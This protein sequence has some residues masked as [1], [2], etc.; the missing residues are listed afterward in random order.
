MPDVL[1]E[2]TFALVPAYRILSL[3]DADA[4]ADAGYDPGNALGQAYTAV[5]AST[6]TELHLVCA[7]AQVPVVVTLRL[8][9]EDPALTAQRDEAELTAPLDVEFATGLVVLSSPTAE[10][11]DVRLATGAGTYA[12][13]VEHSGRTLAEQHRSNAGSANDE[14]S[15]ERYT[16]NLWRTGDIK[17]D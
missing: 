9:Q 11:V 4:D 15:R 16:I 5:V 8:W 17:H 13:V 12:A 7:Q 3:R 2:R 14:V 6:G 1:D 10:A